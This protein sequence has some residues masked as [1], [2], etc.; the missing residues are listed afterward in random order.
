MTGRA[1][2]SLLDDVH[3]AFRLLRTNVRRLRYRVWSVHPTAYLGPRCYLAR[4][5]VV[6]PHAYIGIESIINP[7]VRIGAYTMLG[8]RVCIIGNDHTIDQLGIP[9]IFSGRPEFRQTFIGRDVW[10]GAG[11]LILAGVTI[12]DG[13]VVGAGSVV[14]KSIG[15]CEIVGGVPARLIRH[16]FSGEE[17]RCHL[18]AIN[19]PI[20]RGRL[21]RSL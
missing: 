5:V 9:I 17:K 2:M 18:E 11:A 14:T 7:G 16:R 19:G 10:I 6:G 3:Y 21:P 15:E 4:D 13:S 20:W 12:G 1:N 8:P